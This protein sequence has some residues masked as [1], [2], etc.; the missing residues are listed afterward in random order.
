[1]ATTQSQSTEEW[2]AQT[3]EGWRNVIEGWEWREW[4]EGDTHIG[5]RKWGPCPRCGDTMAVYQEAIKAF[6]DFDTVE[7]RCNCTSDHAKRPEGV[8]GGCGAGFGGH[9]R[10]QAKQAET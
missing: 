4:K 5:W 8:E 7:A 3:P 1:M 2:V 10:I 6:D 9:V